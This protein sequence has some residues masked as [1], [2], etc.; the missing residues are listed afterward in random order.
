MASGAILDLAEGESIETANPGRPNTAFD[1]FVQSILRQVGV[2]LEIPFE[3]LIGHFTASYSAARAAML[4]AWKFFSTRRKWMADNF[5]QPIY[6]E[7]LMEA[8]LSG[9]IAAPGFLNDPA[10]RKAYCSAEWI[11]PARGAIDEKKE[12]DGA[13]KMIEI[14]AKT[15]AEVTAEMSGG[16]WESKHRQQVKEENRR[17]ADGLPTIAEQTGAVMEET[18]IDE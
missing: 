1:P 6:E 15:R 13:L 7:F 12:A 17:K 9:R 8:V 5:C 3:I 2:A 16:D 14:G 18:T 10:I 11:G 4:S